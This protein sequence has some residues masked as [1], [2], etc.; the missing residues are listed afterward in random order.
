MIKINNAYRSSMVYNS[1]YKSNYTGYRNLKRNQ[2]ELM[3]SSK[4]YFG[5]LLQ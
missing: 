5:A 1:P 3:I 4:M 2:N